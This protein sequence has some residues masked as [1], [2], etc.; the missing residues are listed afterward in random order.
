MNTVNIGDVLVTDFGCT[1]TLPTF[2]KVT[3]KTAKTI[4]MV[5]LKSKSVD[6][7]GFTGHCIPTDEEHLDTY[8]SFVQARIQEN[9]G[10]GFVAK[11]S[12]DRR[13][14]YPYNGK[15]AYYNHLD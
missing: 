3:K 14:Y 6:G 5:C 10:T 11:N 15:P 7:D 1:M 8:K 12:K 9:N 4:W 2:Y 13:Y